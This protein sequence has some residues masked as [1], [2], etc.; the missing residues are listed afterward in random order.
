MGDSSPDGT[1]T[2]RLRTAFVASLVALSTS[3]APAGISAQVEADPVLNGRALLGDTA[4]TRGTVVLHHLTNTTQGEVD[5][6]AV[7]PDGSFSFR[8]PN[9][10]DPDRGDVFFA[11]IR[12]EGVSYFGSFVTTASQLDSV[13][14]IQTYDTLLAPEEGVDL[15]IEIRTVFFEAVE[16]RWRV[17]DVFQLANSRARTVVTREPG[18]VW[19]YPLAAG[20]AEF[21]VGEGDVGPDVIGLED[22]DLVLRAPMS[23]GSRMFVVRY[24]LDDMFTVI[25]TPGVIDQFEVLIREPAPLME[26]EGLRFLTRVELEVGS[27][28][29][30][31]SGQ[32]VD[33]ASI[34]LVA[35]DAPTQP[36]VKWVAVVLAVLLAGM[37]LFALRGTGLSLA[38]E[39]PVSPAA[40]RHSLLVQVARLDDDFEAQADPNAAA[41]TL[42]ERRRRELLRRIRGAP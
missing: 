14:A 28:Y 19:R 39:T 34:R 27:T 11:S 4:L 9:V 30:R 22:G 38:G 21:A 15:Q 10:P 2:N 8:L 5:S 32:S 26:V 37:G 42:Y 36:P 20:A 40:D 6:A 7:A 1:V 18:A 29:R 33:L 35:I 12:R 24:T 17:T 41:R 13:Y 16:N 31:Y 3:A 23:P 25:P